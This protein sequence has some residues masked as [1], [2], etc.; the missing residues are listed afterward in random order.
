MIIQK[1][2]NAIIQT[3]LVITASVVSHGLHS[4]DVTDSSL[5]MTFSS[6]WLL[7]KYYIL[8][9]MSIGLLVNGKL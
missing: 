9:R 3:K 6:V 4:D 2:F 7:P 5:E 1:M 8:H